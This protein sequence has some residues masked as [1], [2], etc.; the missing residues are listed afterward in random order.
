MR[1][2]L[3][4]HTFHSKCSNMVPK[5]I[6]AVA[7]KEGLNGI[8]ITDHDQI[9]GAIEVKRLNKDKRLEVIIGEEVSTDAGHVLCYY[10]KEPIRPGRFSTVIGKAMAQEAIV[11]IAHPY[12]F[13]RKAA[14]KAII[15]KY[16]NRIHAIETFN[17]RSPIPFFNDFAFRLSKDLSLASIAGSDAHFPYEIGGAVTVFNTTLRKAIMDRSTRT[18]GSALKGYVGLAN[19]ALLKFNVHRQHG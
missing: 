1:Y 16:A 2:D 14:K 9:N 15:R 17:S 5:E 10:L 13:F 8:A 4:V 11:A 18:E 19:T 6:L 3:H 12:D 7:K